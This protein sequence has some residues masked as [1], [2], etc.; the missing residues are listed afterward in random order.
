M[1][2]ALS[3]DTEAT[4]LEQDCHLIQ[5]GC[6]PLDTEKRWVESDLG[7]ELWIRC[8]SFEELRPSLNPW[9][10]EHNEE[11]IRKA[12]ATG[13]PPETFKTAVQ[14]YLDSRPIKN[15]F[16]KEK[17]IVLGKSLS[18]L[19]IRLLQRYL[20]IS[21]MQE[22]F[23]HHTIDVTS[24]ARYLVDSNVL[25][26]GCERTSGIIKHLGIREEPSH[27]A[28]NDATDMASVYIKLLELVGPARKS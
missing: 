8:P 9:V 4:G 24:V 21:F 20:G 26:E 28:L 27:T 22:R 19:D 6:V 11:L 18:A 13:I 2:L 15:F 14:S 10:V 3:I 1:A 12:H 17:P 5:F 16:G 23:H 7:I 25:P